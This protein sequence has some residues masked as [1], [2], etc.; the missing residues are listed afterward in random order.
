MHYDSDNTANS[1]LPP[2]TIF[3]LKKRKRELVMLFVH[4]HTSHFT[5]SLSEFCKEQDYAYQSSSP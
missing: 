4:G 3:M 5:I 2:M 1:L